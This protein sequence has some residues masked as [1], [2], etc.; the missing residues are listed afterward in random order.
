[1]QYSADHN[2]RSI[3]T[4]PV[5][6]DS[7]K[8]METNPYN[9]DKG[10]FD[11][12][13]EELIGATGTNESVTDKDREIIHN[14]GLD[15]QVSI[16][17]I[18]KA[19]STLDDLD[20]EIYNAD[21]KL[22]GLKK[23]KEYILRKYIPQQMQYM[24]I[25]EV[26]TGAGHRVAVEDHIYVVVKDTLKFIQYVREAG[27]EHLMNTTFKVKKLTSSAKDIVV[28][29]INGL[30]A[31]IS[32]TEYNMHHSTKR[33]FF[34]GQLIDKDGNDNTEEQER[35]SEFGQVKKYYE[36]KIKEGESA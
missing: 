29:T 34:K 36:A 27:A 35:V 9:N 1:M 3:F 14:S 19:I 11:L 2:P 32:G 15:T 21:K 6:R 24:G 33:K 13:D 16:N 12:T 7:N 4:E 25:K 23:T 31:V 20:V 5:K 8:D 17:A 30:G 28:D 10:L 26:V 18:D 22:N